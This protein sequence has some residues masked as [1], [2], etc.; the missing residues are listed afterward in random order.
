MI[1]N[2]F[3]ASGNFCHLLISFANRLDPE[4]DGQRWFWS[5]SK[6]FDTLIEFLNFFVEKLHLKKVREHNKSMKN[7][8]ACKELKVFFNGRI[9]RI[10]YHGLLKLELCIPRSHSFYVEFSSGWLDLLLSWAKCMVSRFFKP[11]KFYCIT[12]IN[13]ASLNSTSF[14]REKIFSLAP[15]I[16]KTPKWVL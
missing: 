12:I 9:L 8:P 1:L 5:G 10:I 4:Q 2:S 7:F 14:I 16:R 15:F 11:L 6:R 13:F 3:L